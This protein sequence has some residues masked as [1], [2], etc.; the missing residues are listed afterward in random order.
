MGSTRQPKEGCC[1]EPR[2]SI[3]I[4]VVGSCGQYLRAYCAQ[5]CLSM[6]RDSRP[7]TRTFNYLEVVRRLWSTDISLSVCSLSAND[8]FSLILG[9]L[10][11]NRTSQDCECALPVRLT[12]L[13]VSCR[14]EQDSPRHFILVCLPGVIS[15][16]CLF[17]KYIDS[18]YD[19]FENR[20]ICCRWWW[21][22]LLLSKVV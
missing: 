14:W 11:T 7:R 3:N 21:L 9:V 13:G 5:I 18:E 15:M 16:C 1:S 8:Q 10:H 12:S 4:L 2:D 17:W 6:L 19:F 22:L 20:V